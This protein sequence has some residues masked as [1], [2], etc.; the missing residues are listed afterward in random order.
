MDDIST[1]KQ[2]SQASQ[3]VAELFKSTRQQQGYSLDQV[4]HHLRVSKSYLEAI[5]T[6]NV[7]HF[8]ARVYILGF[9]KSYALFLNL[10][11]DECCKRFKSEVLG[12]QTTGP[13][14]NFPTLLTIDSS[15]S[16]NILKISLGLVALILAAG[17]FIWRWQ[18]PVTDNSLLEKNQEIEPILESSESETQ[19][20]EARTP[21][22]PSSQDLNKDMN[23]GHE[24][25]FKDNQVPSALP[26]LVQTAEDVSSNILNTPLPQQKMQSINFA[27]VQECWVKIQD[28]RQ[29]IL[30]EK[31]FQPGESYSLPI[32]NDY[33]LHTGNAGGIEVSGLAISPKT[34]GKKGQVIANLS[35]DSGTLSA[36]LNQQ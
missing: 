10:N 27:F 14:L 26:D 30:I 35:L 5:E 7:A 1:T 12:E 25:S 20:L 2:P 18:T 23:H 4:G 22:P 29:Q 13:N 28:P 17:I 21:V 33:T 31:T 19:I 6:N 32:R 9:V 8:P 11:P 15:P 16:L 36:Y 24:S 3:S 34:L